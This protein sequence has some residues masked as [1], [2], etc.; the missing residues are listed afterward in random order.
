MAKYTMTTLC[1]K[2]CY[3]IPCDEFDAMQATPP[4]DAALADE[5]KIIAGGVRWLGQSDMAGDIDRIAAALRARAVTTV[6]DAK[7]ADV[8]PE[9]QDEY[10]RGW[11]NCR[12][13]MLAASKG[14]ATQ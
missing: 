3:V 10:E 5:L 4:A 1:G 2:P 6:P 14:G 12:R 13:A 8:E 7:A 9:M 11:N